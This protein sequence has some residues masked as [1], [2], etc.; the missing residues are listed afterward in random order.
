MHGSYICFFSNFN[1]SVY[2]RVVSNLIVGCKIQF[3][4]EAFKTL[5]AANFFI[6]TVYTFH[7]YFLLYLF[8]KL[9]EY[10]SFS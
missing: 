5:F 8:V 9:V 3:L 4:F 6:N 2:S 7:Y 10:Y 1:K